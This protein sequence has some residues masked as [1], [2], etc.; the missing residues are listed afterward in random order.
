MTLIWK[1]IHQRWWQDLNRND[2]ANSMPAMTKNPNNGWSYNNDNDSR[3]AIE[4]Y[5]GNPRR[6]LMDDAPLCY[7]PLRAYTIYQGQTYL[8]LKPRSWAVFLWILMNIPLE[9]SWRAHGWWCGP[10]VWYDP[11]LLKIWSILDETNIALVNDVM[12]SD[13]GD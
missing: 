11:A 4:Q 7:V 5:Q 6:G 2:N 8:S 1:L 9:A 10:W 3:Q 12:V 13:D